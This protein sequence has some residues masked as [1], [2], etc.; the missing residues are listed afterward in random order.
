M[1]I[2]I[3]PPP[4]SSKLKCIAEKLQYYLFLIQMLFFNSL[5]LKLFSKLDQFEATH[6]K[7]FLTASSGIQHDRR[8]EESSS[9][10]VTISC[11]YNSF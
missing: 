7:G 10:Q 9:F 1:A 3:P 5:G 4:T 11:A 8:A 2:Q 6:S